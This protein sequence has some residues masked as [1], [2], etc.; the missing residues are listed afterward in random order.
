MKAKVSIWPLLSAKV[1][2]EQLF[3]V[4]KGKPMKT[5]CARWLSVLFPPQQSG[6]RSKVRRSP[7][8]QQPRTCRQVPREEW[9][10]EE[11]EQQRSTPQP[12]PDQQPT[13]TQSKEQPP[14]AQQQSLPVDQQA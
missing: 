1:L 8:V 2:R 12:E 7:Q 5:I 13:T 11:S 4:Q 6:N 3:G 14:R 9:R 10:E